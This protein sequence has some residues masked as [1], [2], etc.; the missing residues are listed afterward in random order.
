M[1]GATV[2]GWRFK[3]DHLRSLP[4]DIVLTSQSSGKDRIVLASAACK[5][6]RQE[7]HC[8]LAVKSP[9]VRELH[10]TCTEIKEFGLFPLQAF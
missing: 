6:K 9:A 8:T 2:L 3:Q 10:F 4:A 5:G 1:S 7:G